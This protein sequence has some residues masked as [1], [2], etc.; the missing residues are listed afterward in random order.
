MEEEEKKDF[1]SIR[2]FLL[3]LFASLFTA[4]IS[5][6]Y[7]FARIL[8]IILPTAS[9]LC[10]FCRRGTQTISVPRNVQY[11]QLSKTL[12]VIINSTISL[13]LILSINDYSEH[14]LHSIEFVSHQTHQKFISFLF[15]SFQEMMLTYRPSFLSV[16]IIFVNYLGI[17]AQLALAMDFIFIFNLPTILLYKLLAKVYV[18]LLQYVEF[19][20][21]VMTRNKETW[22][23]AQEGKSFIIQMARVG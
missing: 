11:L 20:W 15:P 14:F 16:I 7:F 3:A 4:F 19:L 22:L 6:Y 18:L 1:H 10:K 23:T 9:L 21:Q 17:T 12:Q 8:T 5:A 13:L 2:Y